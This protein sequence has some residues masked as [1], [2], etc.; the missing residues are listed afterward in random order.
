[1]STAMSRFTYMNDE[2]TVKSAARVLDVLELL[3]TVGGGLGVSE[4]ARRL[5]FPK[6]STHMLLATLEARRYVLSCGKGRF[7]L[8]PMLG[9]VGRGWV[10][11][12]RA[13]LIG[14]ARPCM[15]RLMQATRETVFLAARRDEESL[16]YL[17]KVV[18]L[19]D[20]RIDGD[21]GTRRELHAM[22]AGLVFLA[23]QAEERTA[24]FLEGRSF[25]RYTKH[26]ATDA[27]HLRQ[28]IATTRRKGY[29]LVWDTHALGAA[30]LAAPIRFEDGSIAGS[31]VIG[32]PTV[33]LDRLRRAAVLLLEEADAV[34]DALRKL[35]SV[36]SGS[37]GRMAA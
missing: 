1:M 9:G 32:A 26:T 31:L 13:S 30:G 35:T 7:S 3:S 22:S 25:T 23:Y 8:H 16:E 19:E 29:A 11:G 5:E 10:G 6:S 18:G 12:I 34:G 4:I 24:K 28:L 27:P 21:L 36:R 37:A 14:A 15:L 17:D 33:R 2:G 20:V